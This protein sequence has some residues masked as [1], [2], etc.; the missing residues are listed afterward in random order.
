MQRR[1]RAFTPRNRNQGMGDG[2]GPD[3]ERSFR[4]DE[5]GTLQLLSAPELTFGRRS[6]ILLPGQGHFRSTRP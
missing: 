1:S 4:R 3:L 6:V 5:V 2:H